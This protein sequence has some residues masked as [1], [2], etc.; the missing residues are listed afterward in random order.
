MVSYLR[1]ALGFFFC[2]C[3]LGCGRPPEVMLPVAGEVKVE[4][5]PL[6]KGSVALFPDRSKGNHTEHEPR[7]VVEAGRYRI[8][9]HPR[10]GAPA[11]WYK[12]AVFAPVP[13]DPANPYSATRSAIPERFNQPADSGLTIEVRPNAP[14]GAYDLDLK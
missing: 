9:T 14:P 8:Q 5:K 7:G 1:P 6:E 3:L 13:V 10:E 2:V 11:G 4:G 12:V